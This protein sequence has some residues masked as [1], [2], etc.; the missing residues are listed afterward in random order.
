MGSKY[1]IAVVVG[2]DLGK[3]FA[4]TGV[5]VLPVHD[6]RRTA[7]LLRD[8]ARS[9]TWG[10]II[11][12]EKLLAGIDERERNALFERTIPLLITIP[13]TLHRRDVEQASSDEFVARLI[14]RAVGYQLNI[15]V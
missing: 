9:R 15:Q 2:E 14:R 5:E 6:I 7:E 4:L 8:A 3:G 1:Q 11:V 13:G 10:I 12:D